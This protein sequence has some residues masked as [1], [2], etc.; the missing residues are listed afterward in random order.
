MIKKFVHII[1]INIFL[2]FNKKNWLRNHLLNKEKFDYLK[3]GSIYADTQNILDNLFNLSESRLKRAKTETP[4]NNQKTRTKAITMLIDLFSPEV[5]F[6]TGTLVGNTTEFFGNFKSKVTSV[7][8]SELYALVS[9]IRFLDKKNIEIVLG[10]SA[11]V[12]K[13]ITPNKK[14]ILFYLDA[15]SHSHKSIPLNDEIN[16]CLKF[17]NSIILIDDFKV[18][19][20][21]EFGFDSYE[22]IDLSIESYPVLNNYDLYFP[23]YDASQDIGQRGYVVVDTSGKLKKNIDE[24][25]PLSIYRSN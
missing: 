1:Q 9:K 2:I 23:N 22:D 10:D 7:E 25:F 6:E 18:P 11:E 16:H 19:N 12:L 3:K 15:H 14:K 4:F 20:K 5:I 21:P 17:T 24:R 8:I 13:K